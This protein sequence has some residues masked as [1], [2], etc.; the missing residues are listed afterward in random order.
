MTLES[1]NTLLDCMEHVKEPIKGVERPTV[2]T[3]YLKSLAMCRY[4]LINTDR[5]KQDNRC[6]M[7]WSWR[8]L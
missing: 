7:L 5:D 8:H 6:D 1:N 3:C 4:T 2:L